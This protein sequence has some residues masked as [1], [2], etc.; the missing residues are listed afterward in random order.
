MSVSIYPFKFDA[1]DEKQS[2]KRYLLNKMT[3][4]NGKLQ[5]VMDYGLNYNMQKSSENI[6]QKDF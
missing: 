6:K 2:A 1:S 5:H 4:Q 3:W